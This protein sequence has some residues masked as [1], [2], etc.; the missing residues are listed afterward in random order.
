MIAHPNSLSATEAVRLI[1]LGKLSSEDLVKACLDRIAL[2]DRAVNAWACVDADSALEQARK[3]DTWTGPRGP[4]HGIP[5]GV[6]D[7][8]DT[9]DMPTEYGSQIYSGHRPPWDAACVALA[10]AAGAVVIG[11]TATTEFANIHPAAT[12]NP[13]N[14]LHSPGGSSSGSA[15]AI[16]DHM[17]PI[18]FGTQTAGSTIR[19]AAF[20]GVM[21][22]K[23]SF[24]LISRFGLKLVAESLDTVGLL[25]RSLD[26]LTLLMKVVSAHNMISLK[27][28]PL[29]VPRIGVYLPS[30]LDEAEPSACDL[31]EQSAKTLAAA[32]ASVL[33]C[34]SRL[35]DARL[36]IA[37][38]IIMGYESARSMS[39]EFSERKA[40]LSFALAARLEEGVQ[41]TLGRY[42]DALNDACSA[43]HE[44]DQLMQN[45]DVVI[46]LS[47]SGEAPIG[48]ES[49]GSSLFNRIWTLLGAPCIHLPCALGP[50]SLPL[51]IQIIGPLHQDM[52]FLE[53]AQWISQKLG[54]TEFVSQHFL[55]S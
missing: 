30:F 2:R 16:A 27:K 54:S 25:G 31:L 45:F 51:G 50:N 24:G 52:T 20:C 42:E 13:H 1:L 6:K 43:R 46:T 36:N 37:H 5:I 22:Y 12:R 48:I 35:D 55:A 39:Y 11:K 33:I 14:L 29:T 7:V 21:A 32:G 3:R 41:L 47:A 49:T 53:H 34:N 15:A 17:I 8:I 9:V 10:R 40:S 18:A 38:S 4:L 28:G 23:P 44:F 26:D 19:P